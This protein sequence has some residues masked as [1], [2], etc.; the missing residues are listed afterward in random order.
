MARADTEPPLPSYAYT[1]GFPGTFGFP[2]VAVFGLTPIAANGLLT[3]LADLLRGGTELP[4]GAEFLGLFD[5][6]LRGVLLD[7]DVEARSAF[8]ATAIA[9]HRGAGF[10][11]V[12]LLWPDRNG[13]LPYEPGFEQRLRLAQPVLGTAPVA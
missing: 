10:D 2:E 7:V 8:F 3:M 5:G 13:F 4:I 6:E 12:Q 9:W 11:V 1:I